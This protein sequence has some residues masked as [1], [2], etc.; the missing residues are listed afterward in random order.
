MIQIENAIVETLDATQARPVG[1]TVLVV[2]IGEYEFS[3]LVD[4]G[5]LVEALASQ[6]RPT[7]WGTSVL[8]G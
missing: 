4:E 8:K 3:M 2:T 6:Y 1:S 5:E 7:E